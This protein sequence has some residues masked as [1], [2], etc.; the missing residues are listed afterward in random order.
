[1]AAALVRLDSEGCILWRATP[2]T[3]Q[4]CFVHATCDG[5]TLTANTW[6]CYLV[7]VDL[8]NGRVTVLAFTK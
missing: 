7:S 2:P 6:S 3:T 8:Q 1:M 5:R 4:D